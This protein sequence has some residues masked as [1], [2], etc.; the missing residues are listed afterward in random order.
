MSCDIDVHRDLLTECKYVSNHVTNRSVA[1]FCYREA[2]EGICPCD[3]N[4]ESGKWCSVPSEH[5]SSHMAA[6]HPYGQEHGA[7]D[8]Q[9]VACMRWAHEG[10]WHY[11]CS[12]QWTNY[13][14]GS[15]TLQVP[16]SHFGDRAV[17][18]V[19]ENLLNVHPRRILCDV[20]AES[21]DEENAT[22]KLKTT[23]GV[24]TCDDGDVPETCNTFADCCDT[25]H[26][27]FHDFNDF[28]CEPHRL[29]DGDSWL[30]D[31]DSWLCTS[32]HNG[33]IPLSELPAGTMCG[34]TFAN[35]IVTTS[36]T[37]NSRGM[38]VPSFS[39]SSSGDL[40]YACGAR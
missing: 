6:H 35:D 13:R 1:D 27:N 21:S 39:W 12:P 40:S 33:M 26:K 14:E 7:P 5:L 23:D 38:P 18:V 2:I 8:P 20:R 9:D 29:W 28:F 37:E 15:I 19:H 17:C 11:L 16:F 24:F 30:W 31:G 3:G 10:Q 4:D 25:F 22:L 34:L 36:Y 32:Q